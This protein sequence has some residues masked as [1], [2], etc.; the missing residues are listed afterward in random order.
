MN[1]P[2]KIGIIGVGRWGINY[3]RTFNELNN[4]TVK[5]ICATKESTLKEALIKVNLKSPVETTTNSEDILEDKEVDAVAIVTPGTTHYKLIKDALNSNKHTIVEKPVAFHSKDVE[6]L[7]KISKEK[8]KILMVGHLHLFNSG[9]QRV[10]QDIKSNLFGN[11]NYIHL[12]HFGNGPIRND[13]NALWDF[14]PHTVSILL[15]LL[16]KSPLRLSVNGASYVN[17]GIE[18]VV[19]MD[20]VFPNKIFAM[21]IASWLYPLKKMD[22][23]IVGEKLYATFEDYAKDEKL[24]YYYS[25][26]KIVKKRIL[27]QDK[28][29]IAPKVKD[30]KPLTEQLKHFLYCIKK[31]KIPLTDGHEALKVVKVL[32]AAQMSLKNDGLMVEVPQ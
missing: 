10:K 22:I 28:G 7:I 9:I 18:D 24:K 27:I 16:E 6:D 31:N 1:K 23:I 26:P 17:K 30:S 12:S 29:Y 4:A 13:M 20:M 32:E 8:R 19:T 2:L 3:L 21:S 5:W 14:F 15:Y 11:I 25:R